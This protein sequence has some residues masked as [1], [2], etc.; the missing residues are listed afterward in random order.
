MKDKANDQRDDQGQ[1]NLEQNP[2]FLA[3]FISKYDLWFH[4]SSPMV[5]QLR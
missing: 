4:R 5:L 2:V 3:D 1:R